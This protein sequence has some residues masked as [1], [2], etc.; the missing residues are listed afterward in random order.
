[1]KFAR[2]FVTNAVIGGVLVVVPV[3]LAVLLLLQ[4]MKAVGQL[5]RPVAMLLPEWLPAVDLLSLLLVLA[6]CFFVGLAVRTRAGRAL[7]E[8]MEVSFFGR[9]R[10]MPCF[11]A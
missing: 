9:I 5:V 3:Y 6:V 2:E 1:M 11:A 10:A 4:G 7:R 8:R